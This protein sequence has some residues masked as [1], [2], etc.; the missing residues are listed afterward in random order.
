MKSTATELKRNQNKHCF[1]IHNQFKM[2]HIN[3]ICQ[4]SA[5]RVPGGYKIDK[6]NVKKLQQYKCSLTCTDY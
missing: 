6:G 2:I 3:F 4:K 5:L 1:S